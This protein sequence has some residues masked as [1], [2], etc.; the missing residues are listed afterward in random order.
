MAARPSDPS[1]RRQ[2]FPTRM[3]GTPRIVQAHEPDADEQRA[4]A[5]EGH[6]QLD[7]EKYPT[8]VSYLGSLR[9]GSRAAS[10]M[11]ARFA[12]MEKAGRLDEYESH[13]AKRVSSRH[14]VGRRPRTGRVFAPPS[15]GN[16]RP[17]N[18]RPP[19]GAQARRRRGSY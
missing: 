18:Q 2:A 13:L 5:G 12:R 16:P 11:G 4:E 10:M 17:A 19:S 6:G 7:K 8:I 9:P 15:G 1:K 14:V 3:R